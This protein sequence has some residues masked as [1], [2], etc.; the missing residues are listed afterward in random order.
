MNECATNEPRQT[1]QDRRDARRRA[2]KPVKPYPHRHSGT[3]LVVGGSKDA[4]T[5]LKRASEMRPGAMIMAVGHAA[6][7]T[8]VDFVVSD[9]YEV[10]TELRRLQDAFGTGHYSTHCTRT[11][12]RDTFPEVDYW[13]NWRRSE[14]S[15]VQTAI[16]IGLA[17]GFQE[18]ILCGCPLEH[19]TV[20]HPAQIEKDGRS[21]PP[22]RNISRYGF[23]Q[24]QNTSEEILA[25]FRYYL[26]ALSSDWEGVV[27]SLGAFPGVVGG[28]PPAAPDYSSSLASVVEA[29]S[30]SASVAKA[31]RQWCGPRGA[32]HSYPSRY[33]KWPDKD[34]VDILKRLCQGFVC[35]VGCGTGRCCEAFQPDSYVGLDVN[36]HVVK[37]ARRA[38]PRHSFQTVGWHDVYPEADTYLFYTMLLH[39][40][41][42]EVMNVLARTKHDGYQP[43]VVV[44]ET[45][46]R[47]YRSEKQGNYQRDIHEY[48]DMMNRTGRRIVESMRLSSD[49]PP[50]FRHFLVTE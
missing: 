37:E 23:K 31:L 39:V 10:H 42:D 43:R 21:W 12:R 20:Q 49:A 48:M 46:C 33:G 44:F 19:G 18:I 22:A 24:G 38:Y 34:S 35:E 47:D 29:P 16:R 32:S 27:F 40:P 5:E 8:K 50:H 2:K 25:S 7:M 41:D 4:L 28:E 45:M 30:V 15:S 6:G 17:T 3:L 14:A 26:V 13:W 1:A 11:S 36:E 9:H